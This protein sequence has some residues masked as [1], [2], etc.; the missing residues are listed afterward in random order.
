MSLLTRK[1]CATLYLSPRTSA[2]PLRLT[3]R[4]RAKVYK[5][6]KIK[7]QAVVEVSGVEGADTASARRDVDALLERM[8]ALA[9]SS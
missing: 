3:C 4:R 5:G 2:L 7:A 9:A 8:Q 1:S 6:A